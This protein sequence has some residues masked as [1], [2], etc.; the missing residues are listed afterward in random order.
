MGKQSKNGAKGN[1]LIVEDSGDFSN[2][3][4]FIVEDEG[5]V[6]VQ[7]PVEGDDIVEWAKNHEPVTILMDLALR[8][9]GGMQFVDDLKN[10]PSTKNI[11]IIIITGRELSSKDIFDLQMRDV[12]YLRKGRIEMEELKRE[13][14]ESARS[15]KTS[16]PAKKE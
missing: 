12:K 4:K 10:D 8:R 2:L 14:L 11:P 9:R 5:Y 15:T 3:L 16:P 7:F 1:I 13:I 6:G